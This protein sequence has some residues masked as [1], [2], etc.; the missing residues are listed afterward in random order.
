MEKTIDVDKIWSAPLSA[1]YNEAVGHFN[2]S[3]EICVEDF[4]KKDAQRLEDCHSCKTHLFFY[5][6]ELI[7]YYT[8][9]ADY[10]NIV[11]SKREHAGWENIVS[12]MNK[13]HFPSVRIHY[14]G[15]DQKFRGKGFGEL[16]LLFA[17]VT[18]VEI[19]NYLG[20]S[21]VVLEAVQNSVS[22]FQKM[23]FTKIKMDQE[24]QIMGIKLDD[25]KEYM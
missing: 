10:I 23:N 11:K 6:K 3:D 16:L 8:L 22:F 14:I 4:L 7:G 21:F 5:E 9:F 2:C 15:V 18:C 20:F 25:I 19:S 17:L 1:K 24:L 12:T 13:Q